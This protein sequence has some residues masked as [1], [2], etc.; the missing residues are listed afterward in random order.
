MAYLFGSLVGGALGV[1][2]ITLIIEMFAFKSKRPN[3]RAALTVGAAIVV[4]AI[5]TGFTMSNNG[6]FNVMSWLMYA[7]GAVAVFFWRRHVYHQ[8]WLDDE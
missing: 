7:P 3:E 2:L 5:V 4:I 8:A 6:Q 1:V